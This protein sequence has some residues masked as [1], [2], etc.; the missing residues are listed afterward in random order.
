MVDRALKANY[1]PILTVESV[2]DSAW[3]LS[4]VLPVRLGPE[5]VVPC[6]VADR[7]KWHN[8][9]VCMQQAATPAVW[10]SSVFWRFP[11][12]SF[13]FVNSAGVVVFLFFSPSFY[14]CFLPWPETLWSCV[15]LFNG[16]ELR[17]LILSGFKH[18]KYWQRLI[19]QV[20]PLWC[21][22]EEWLFII[23]IF[24]FF[25][26]SPQYFEKKVACVHMA[27]WM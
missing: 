17:F 22:N 4:L 21:M 11:Q 26:D 2:A 20:L 10:I 3:C 18:V 16:E 12:A 27:C 24:S 5:K 23:I 14:P 19:T 25:C 6:G 13:C 8:P 7:Y 15:C 1:L 9:A